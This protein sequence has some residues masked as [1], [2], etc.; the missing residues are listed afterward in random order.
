M[1]SY[2]SMARRLEALEAEARRRETAMV[3]ALSDEEL[4]AQIA[5]RPADP[6]LEA[7]LDALSFEQLEIV[8]AGKIP[9]EELRRWYREREAG[10]A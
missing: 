9:E 8:A 6:E 3:A 10:Q 2:K 5:N 7:A 4:E 1:P